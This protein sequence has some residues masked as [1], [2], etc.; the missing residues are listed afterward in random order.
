MVHVNSEVAVTALTVTEPTESGFYWV[1]DKVLGYV[2]P[3]MLSDR[4]AWTVI[5]EPDL[6]SEEDFAKRY[7]V[8]CEIVPPDEDR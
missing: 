7:E 8:V 5:S 4:P 1:K 2:L 3:A 6:L